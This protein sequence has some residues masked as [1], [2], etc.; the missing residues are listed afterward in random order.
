MLKFI[1]ISSLLVGSPTLLA[2]PIDTVR[3]PAVATR[4]LLTAKEL[5]GRFVIADFWATWC[6]SCRDNLFRLERALGGSFPSDTRFVSVNTDENGIPAVREF[7]A[8]DEI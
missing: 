2:G 6:D 4:G 5:R 8:L 1:F 7:F 3:M